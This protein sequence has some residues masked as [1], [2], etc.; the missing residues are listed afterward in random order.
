MKARP[1]KAVSVRARAS[2][3]T[4]WFASGAR[5]TPWP[6]WVGL[7]IAAWR[8]HVGVADGGE[9]VSKLYR[10][11]R[12]LGSLGELARVAAR[13]TVEA[14][15]VSFVDLDPKA[16]EEVRI[17]APVIKEK[18]EDKTPKEPEK[19]KEEPKPEEKKIIVQPDEKPKDPALPMR[20][21]NRVAIQ[22]HVKPNQDDNPNANQIA[23]DANKVAEETRATLTAH[24]QDNPDPTMGSNQSTADGVADSDKTK[25][26]DSDDRAGKKDKAPGERGQEATLLTPMTPKQSSTVNEATAK[27]ANAKA[28]GDQHKPGA[29]AVDTPP[30]TLPTAPQIADGQGSWSFNPLQPKGAAGSSR[31]PGLTDP[32][33]PFAGHAGPQ[34]MGLGVEAGPGRTTLSLSHSDVLA[35]FS[36][37]ELRKERVADGERRKSEHRGKW[38]GG[39]FKRWKPAIE[40]YVASVKPGNTTALN[41]A[42]SP[43]AKYLHEMH[44]RIHPIFADSFLGSIDGLPPSNPL[45]NITMITRLEIVLTPN[46]GRV[47]KMGIVKTSGVTSFDVAALDSVDRA[48][49]YGKAPAAIISADGNVY[50]HWEFHRDERVACSNQNASPYMLTTP[51]KTPTEDPRGPKRPDPQ[52]RSNENPTDL[53]HGA[54]PKNPDAP[55]EFAMLGR[56][57]L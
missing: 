55:V 18:P 31:G 45:S 50:L 51:P 21:D 29:K 8:F 9:Y 56:N 40:N 48:A 3:A 7:L 53:R 33:N 13:G 25:I 39:D 6:V 26:A 16:A 19:K 52:E 4:A 5:N 10:E 1:A 36:E 11:W 54:L 32:K 49:P 37:D 14:T 22:Q 47:V 46:D 38:I 28:G 43:F 34:V 30:A 15:E 23:E 57:R 24:D 35:V 42:R 12:D 17:D 44:I 41:A 27:L 20:K 2:S